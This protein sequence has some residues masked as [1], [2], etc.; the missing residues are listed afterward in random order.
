MDFGGYGSLL[1]RTAPAHHPLGAGES[2]WLAWRLDPLVVVPAVLLAVLYARGLLCWS[3]R[4]RRHA[5]WQTLLFYVGLATLVLAVVSPLDALAEHHFSM[6]MIQHELLI[7]VGVP[8]L[9]LGAPTTPLLRGLPRPVR[10]NVVR[11]I[12]RATAARWAYS[13]LTH[14]LVALALFTVAL[15]IWHLAPDWYDAATRQQPLHVV[16][17]A[18]F[19]ATDLLFWWNVIDPAP[20]HSRMGYLVRIV[21]VMVAGTAQSVL[22]ALITMADRPLYRIYVEAR[23][24]LDI[25]PLRD[26]ELGGLIMWIPGQMMNLL[27]VAALF[28]VWAVRSEREQRARE[29]AAY[30]DGGR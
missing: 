9:L 7:A 14:P 4:S 16:Q 30:A 10:R 12:A 17:H 26:Q 28:G 2:A 13:G 6:H 1:E 24:I 29:R 11:P 5:P 20:L 19:V 21:Y 8:L 27:V 18:T 25:T 23:P 3:E 15:W 22:A